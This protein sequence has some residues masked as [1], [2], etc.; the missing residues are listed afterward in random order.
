MDSKDPEMNDLYV[1]YKFER[2]L[3]LF[4]KLL[5]DMKKDTQDLLDLFEKV[6]LH[7]FDDP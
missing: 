1:R 3:A 4:K 5:E 2:D 7:F 6:R